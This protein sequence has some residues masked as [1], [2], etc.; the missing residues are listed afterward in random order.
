MTENEL[1][2]FSFMVLAENCMNDKVGYIYRNDF[3]YSK[4]TM[5]K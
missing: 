3:V 4:N 1:V 2:F 5:D